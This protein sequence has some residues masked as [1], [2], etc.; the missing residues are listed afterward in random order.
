MLFNSIPFVILVA[1]T[2]SIYYLSAFRSF[3]VQILICSSII[4]YGYSQPYLLLL[5]ISSASIN[6][7]V[8]YRVAPTEATYRKTIAT[9]GVVFNL[10]VLAFFKYNKLLDGIVYAPAS[11]VGQLVNFALMLPLPIGISFYTFQGI[12]LVMDVYSPSQNGKGKI[13]IADNFFTHY[14]KV[15]FFI[16]FFPQL[17]A[18][19]IVKAHSFFPQ[20]KDKYFKDVDLAYVLQTLILGYFLKSVI[21]DNLK[22]QTFWIAAP[23]FETKSSLTLVVMLFG[24][25]MQI[26]ADFAGYSLIAIGIAALFGYKLP[27]NFNFPYISRSI[28]EFWRRWH[29][30]LSSWLK[31]Y[32][33]IGLL[34]G[35]KK[36][37]IRTYVNLIVVMFLG[38]MWHGAALS[39]GIW[40]LWHGLGLAV[41]RG[42]TKN[43]DPDIPDGFFKQLVQIT[44]V[45]SFVSFGWLLFKLTNIKEA[46]SYLAAIGGNLGIRNDFDIIL[47]VAVYSI[48]VLLYHLQYLARNSRF[49]GVGILE[50]GHSFIYA[51]LLILVLVNGGIPGEFVYFQF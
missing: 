43:K 37:N 20:I 51:L 34:G 32:L 23:Y 28:A 6:A 19:P 7:I 1:L 49:G 44:F 2:F 9:L 41:E 50:R 22:D 8:S 45:F 40:G 15:L 12:S 48:P 27:Q 31:E 11:E 36:G 38:G 14:K 39:F 25:S 30:S 47:N 26:F 3:Q 46:I 5:L 13:E 16:A 29:I 33:Y 10:L 35:N 42:L 21:A 24:Y 17:V 4:F 18:G